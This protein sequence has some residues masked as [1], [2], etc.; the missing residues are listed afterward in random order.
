MSA[1]LPVLGLVGNLLGGGIEQYGAAVQSHRGRQFA[2]EM[3]STQYQRAVADMKAAG[4]NPMAIFGNGGGSPAATPPGDFS[5]NPGRAAAR[6]GDE[7]TGAFSK[8]DAAVALKAQADIARSNARAAESEADLKVAENSAYQAALATDA[9]R[10]GAVTQRYGS[11]GGA[12]EVMGKLGVG[13]VLGGEHSAKSTRTSEQNAKIA[14]QEADRLRAMIE[15]KQWIPP[16]D[17]P[18]PTRQELRDKPWSKYGGGKP[19]N[20]YR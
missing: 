12:G 5:N 10:V 3:A 13:N 20:P 2:R 17:D 16:S 4:L 14:N 8:G 15:K 6:L 11:L 18:Y 7:I 1:A 19:S 9:G